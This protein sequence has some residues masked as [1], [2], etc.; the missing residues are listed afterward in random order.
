MDTDVS[1]SYNYI[2]EVCGQSKYSTVQIHDISFQ[3]V[4]PSLRF[5]L[6]ALPA[7]EWSGFETTWLLERILKKHRFGKSKPWIGRRYTQQ[8]WDRLKPLILQ[9]KAGSN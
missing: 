7:P 1:L 6:Y 8:H 5:N 9:V 2:A 4:L 3:E